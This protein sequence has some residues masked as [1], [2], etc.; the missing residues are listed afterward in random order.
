MF[1]SLLLANDLGELMNEE[2]LP[3]P[4]PLFGSLFGDRFP[5]NPS[6]RTAFFLTLTVLVLSLLFRFLIFPRFKKVP[7]AFQA[8]M[9]KFCETAEGIVNDNS[10]RSRLFLGAFA[11]SSWIYIGLGTL[12]ELLGIRA[13][14]VDLNACIALAVTAYAIMLYGGI[15]YNKLRGLGS[16]LKDVSLLLSMSFRL[17]G[18]MIGGLLM[19]S[20]VYHYLALSVGL[21]VIVGVVFTLF[22]AVIQSYV[23]TLLTAMFYGEASEERELDG[24]QLEK[25][26]KKAKRQKHPVLNPEIRKN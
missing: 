12:C 1:S 19:T 22:H 24:S 8:M 20:L 9:E 17:F 5:V 15:R 10:T 21:P 3:D 4:V 11:F 14:L 16:V 7:G 25:K 18:S 13:V 2:L 26:T 6:F 23:Y